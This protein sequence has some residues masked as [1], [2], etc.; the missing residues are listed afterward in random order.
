MDYGLNYG[1][2]QPNFFYPTMDFNNMQNYMGY[3]PQY[4]S[5]FTPQTSTAQVVSQQQVAQQQTTPKTKEEPKENKVA[6]T[7]D[8]TGLV[9]KNVIET[10]PEKLE[11]YIKAYNKDCTTKT[12]W[13]AILGLSI[14]ALTTIFGAKAFKAMGLKDGNFFKEV[15]ASG[16]KIDDYIM[17]GLLG[18]VPGALTFT[19]INDKGGQGIAKEYF[20]KDAK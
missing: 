10:T 9:N 6:F 8:N 11:E 4:P 1:Y 20:G 5:I 17:N 7:L 3:Y 18:I 13:G 14:V 16:K 19:I 12:T 15:F 2:Y